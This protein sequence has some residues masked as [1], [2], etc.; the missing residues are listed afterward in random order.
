MFYIEQLIVWDSR[1]R[2]TT[3][4]REGDIY[5][6]CPPSV[7][8]YSVRND[9]NPPYKYTSSRANKREERVSVRGVGPSRSRRP[10]FGWMLGGWRSDLFA[11]LVPPFYA[12]CPSRPSSW[13]KS[14][15]KNWVITDDLLWMHCVQSKQEKNIVERTVRFMIT[16]LC[17]GNFYKPRLQAIRAKLISAESKD[18]TSY[19]PSKEKR[20]LRDLFQIVLTS[21]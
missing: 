17:S 7:F 19:N 5:T 20:Q 9:Q 4:T 11:A 16:F 1:M 14:T 18:R 15:R 12:R 3:T 13:L 21:S 10:V 6:T 2:C 8:R